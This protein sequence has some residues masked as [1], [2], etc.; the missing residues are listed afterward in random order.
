MYIL[1]A[2]ASLASFIALVVSVVQWRA[3]A[4]EQRSYHVA[5]R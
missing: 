4:A 1:W 3:V 5:P 2:I